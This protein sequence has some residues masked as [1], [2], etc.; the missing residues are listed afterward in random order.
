[1]GTQPL[2]P[3]AVLSTPISEKDHPPRWWAD[4]RRKARVRAYQEIA[5][6]VCAGDFDHRTM[7]LTCTV[8]LVVGL[9][10]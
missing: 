4:S 2:P 8:V 3:K 10:L 7:A 1:M 9:G 6:G 5:A